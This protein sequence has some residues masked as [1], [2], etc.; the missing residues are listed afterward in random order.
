V[1]QVFVITFALVMICAVD[2]V[3]LSLMSHAAAQFRVLCAMLRDMHEN[4]TEINLHTTRRV[5]SLHS[6]TDVSFTHSW[7]G[8]TERTA[9]LLGEMEYLKNERLKEDLFR[10]YLVECIRHH[11][12]VFA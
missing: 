12:A 5:A 3:F 11:Q 1:L 4:V 2:L 7:S 10:R 6:G 8:D 9:R